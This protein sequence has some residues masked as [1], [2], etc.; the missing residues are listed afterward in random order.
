M[1]DENK[2]RDAADAIKGIVEAVPV[3]QDLAQPAVQEVGKGLQTV[4]KLV[5]VALAPV[6]I[7]VWGYEQIRDYLQETLA[8]KL[9]DVPPERIVQLRMTIAGPTVE[10][11]RFAADEP[12]L[13]ELYANLLATSIDAEKAQDAH[14]A[15]V[16]IIR[17]L[18]PDEARLLVYFTQDA[19]RRA[20]PLL[21]G[22]L[23]VRVGPIDWIHAVKRLCL[24]QELAGCEHPNL[25][26]SYLDNLI[27]LGLAETLP[28]TEDNE[29]RHLSYSDLESRAHHDVMRSIK[30]TFEKEGRQSPTPLPSRKEVTK[31]F[32]QL[33]SL[34][35]Q[36]CGACVIEGTH[37]EG[38]AN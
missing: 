8:E 33:T 5:H 7:V 15:F 26:D 9:K 4:A 3:Y 38:S 16:D 22:K 20:F 27:R 36:F 13:R 37:H 23:I 35:R 11:L 17:Q 25:V 21:T 19:R 34:G 12:T 32:L 24:F 2:I 28:T 10:Q 29:G 30:E 14:P 6:S 18:T 31:H 1:G